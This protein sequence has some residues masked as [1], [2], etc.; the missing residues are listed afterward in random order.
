MAVR[1]TGTHP[2]DYAEPEPDAAIA[3]ETT[4]DYAY[5]VPGPETLACWSRSP[6]RPSIKSIK[7]TVTP[8]VLHIN[9]PG[10]PST[11]RDHI[12][13]LIIMSHRYPSNPNGV[14]QM[15][16][17]TREW[18]SKAEDDYQVARRLVDEKERIHREDSKSAKSV[19]GPA[20][21]AMASVAISPLAGDQRRTRTLARSI[22]IYNR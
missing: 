20:H 18:T 11:P 12:A 22:Y 10:S 13:T 9:S 15:K 17:L 1:T 3:R 6:S 19:D 5:R 21:A 16:K 8:K 7:A 2:R 4:E 14:S